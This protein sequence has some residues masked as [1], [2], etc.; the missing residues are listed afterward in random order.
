MPEPYQV[1][2]GWRA[3]FIAGVLEDATSAGFTGQGPATL[4]EYTAD[5]EQPIQLADTSPYAA[6]IDHVL[7]CLAEHGDN[8]ID[9]ASAIPALELTLDIQ[10]RLTQRAVGSV[11]T[12]S[13]LV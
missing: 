3:T 13:R 12:T 2:G 4:T 11:P 8:R 9:P 1:R 7:T 6:M 10:Q 5:G